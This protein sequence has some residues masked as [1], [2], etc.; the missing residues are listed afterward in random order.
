MAAFDATQLIDVQWYLAVYPDVAAAGVDPIQHYLNNGAAE[1]RD[2][3]H[4]LDSAWYVDQH[5]QA[6]AHPRGAFGHFLDVGL[7]AGYPPHH[8][9]TSDPAWR[10]ITR[11][12]PANRPEALVTSLGYFNAR[13]AV[14]EPLQDPPAVP[15][16]GQAWL[17]VLQAQQAGLA[18]GGPKP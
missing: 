3:G 16:E 9:L 5:P 11:L 14:S 4:W 12:H 2:P 15:R 17:G 7:A 1:C 10:G 8:Q 6:R 13:L 18:G